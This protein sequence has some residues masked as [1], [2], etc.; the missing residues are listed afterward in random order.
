MYKEAELANYGGHGGYGASS[1][2]SASGQ[3][4]TK[5]MVRRVR[6]GSA[7]RVAGTV[8]ALMWAI[9]GLLFVA[10]ATLAGGLLS[11]SMPGGEN[12]RLLTATTTSILLLY[13]AGIFAYGIVGAIFGAL[14]AWLYNLASLLFGGLEIEMS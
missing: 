12:V 6:V 10:F 14:Y 3:A 1:T 13:V 4:R 5:Q 2:F 11:T 8:S 9:I 7:A